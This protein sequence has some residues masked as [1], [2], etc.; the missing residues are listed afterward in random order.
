MKCLTRFFNVLL[1]WVYTFYATALSKEGVGSNYA[2]S[3]GLCPDLI[4]DGIVERAHVTSVEEI[5]RTRV[6]NTAFLI[7]DLYWNWAAFSWILFFFINLSFVILSCVSNK[8]VY[9]P[10]VIQFFRRA[11]RVQRHPGS[12]FVQILQKKRFFFVWIYNSQESSCLPFSKFSICSFVND[13]RFRCSFRFRR[14][15]IWES[16]SPDEFCSELPSDTLSC[17][18]VWRKCG[19]KRPKTIAPI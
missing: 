6:I 1:E 3:A 11:F 7:K 13:V 4:Q 19:E 18:F 9:V 15:R 10:P 5:K 2:T 14:K 12:E 16:S 8:P 17:E